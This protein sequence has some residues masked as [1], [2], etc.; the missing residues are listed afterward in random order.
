MAGNPY[1]MDRQFLAE[2]L[3]FLT[4]GQNSMYMV[5]D[6][7]FVVEFMHWSSLLLLHMS[8]MAEDLITYSSAEFGF[9]QLSDAYSTGSSIMP[10]K[11]NPVSPLIR[12]ELTTGFTGN[13]SRQIRQ[14]L[15]ANVWADDD[16]ERV[17][18]D[19]Q[20]GHGGG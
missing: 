14:S 2:E 5:S 15:W 9:V 19:I 11:K 12:V 7:D 20:Q 6:R 17:A 16:F 13:H 10:Q 1:G 18:V 8:R 3:G 4:V